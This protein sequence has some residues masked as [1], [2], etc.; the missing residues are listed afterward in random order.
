MHLSNPP[1]PHVP[2]PR[3]AFTQAKARLLHWGGQTQHRCST[4]QHRSSRVLGEAL[5]TAGK[6]RLQRLLEFARNYRAHSVGNF[7]GLTGSQEG[8][9]VLRGYLAHETPPPPQDPTVALC[10]GTCDDP[11]G[12][13]FL[14]S[15]VPLYRGRYRAT[16]AQ[17]REARTRIWSPLLLRSAEVPL[18]L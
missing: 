4:V 8:K 18:L 13:F 11:R 1:C 12:C 5:S 17:N 15:E 16:L 3:T 10:L 6:S 14:M 2:S 7:C 9:P